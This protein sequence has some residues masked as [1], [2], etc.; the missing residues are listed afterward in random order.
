MSE[1]IKQTIGRLMNKYGVANFGVAVL[2]VLAIAPL[3][4]AELGSFDAYEIRVIRPK[5]MAKRTRIELTGQ[6]SIVMNQAFIYTFMATGLLN[7]HFNEMFALELGG[8]FGFSVDKEDKRILEEEFNIQ[9]Q[10][11]RT[12]YL[13]SGGLLWTPAY[14]KTQLASGKVL[15][16]DTFLSGG[17]ALTGIDYTYDQCIQPEGEVESEVAPK[18]APRTV[19]YPGAYIGLGQ[20]FF[21]SKDLSLR[22]DIRDSIF[23]YDTNDGSC[24]PD[25]PPEVQRTSSHQN[26]TLSI[27]ATTFF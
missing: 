13:A 16:F 7:Y 9:T 5:Y 17:V 22:W 14:G 18:P 23:A 4:Q 8:S 12:Q 19:S 26:V 24:T 10:I 20:K 3:A 25:E 1:I 2:I 27:G 15:Y 21:V 6:G 11:L